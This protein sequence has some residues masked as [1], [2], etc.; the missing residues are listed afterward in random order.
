MAL[1]TDVHDPDSNLWVKFYRNPVQNN[2][3]S[4]KEGHPCF[5]EKIFISIISPGDQNN[6]V[7]RP[8]QESDK[9][10]FHRQWSNFE[11]GDADKVEGTRIEEWPQITRAQAEELKYLGVRS[12]EQLVAATDAQTQK[13]MG[14]VSLREKARAFLSI[15]KNTAEGQ[16]LADENRILNDRIKALENQLTTLSAKVLNSDQPQQAIP[17]RRGRPPK[18]L[19]EIAS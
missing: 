1:A 15:A 4:A 12:I 16:R 14:G 17:K 11:R 19:Q 3:R 10:R 7:D 9:S 18:Q 5:D 13:I 6:K 8:I 2:V